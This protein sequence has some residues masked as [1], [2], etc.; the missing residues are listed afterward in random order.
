M[1][2]KIKK[3]SL[4]E[5]WKNEARDFTTWL[6]ENIDTLN[7]VLGMN[8]SVVKKEKDVGDF[9][10][11]IL[12]EDENG[13]LV[14]IENQIE[15]TDHDHLGKLVTYLTN[16]NAKTAVWITSQP[17]DEHVKAID[18]LNQFTADDISFYVV[19]VEA[20]TIEDSKAAP[21][22]TIV[23]E[24]S[25]ISK[26]VGKEKKELAERHHLRK[27]FWTE[28]LDRA[29]QKTQLHSNVS[30]CI[31]SWIGAG[32]GKSGIS[33]NYSI[34]YDGA[35][36]EIYLDRGKEFPTLNKVR[37]DE[38]YQY[39]DKIEPSF[40]TKLSWERLDAKRAS[41]IA[42][43]IKDMG[44]KNKENW[45]ILQNKMIDAMVLMEKSFKPYIEKL[46]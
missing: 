41:R 42:Y 16:L 8:F 22:F 21:L 1:I 39:K 32:A 5:I 24:P 29:R 4:R 40:G 25:E 38:L 17:R 35:A 46:K 31:Y 12:A 13:N 30:P 14:I 23:A 43:R 36:V 10:L 6:S 19:K 44:L 3:I 2:G 9:S 11:D 7:E 37:F 33:Y 28:L 18:W 26:E 45:P 34:T 20:I 27:D 15:K